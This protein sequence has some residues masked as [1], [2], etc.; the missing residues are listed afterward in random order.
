M[1]AA[2]LIAT[3]NSDT[4]LMQCLRSLQDF[5][6][7]C[8]LDDGSGPE[9]LSIQMAEAYA[10]A[11]PRPPIRARRSP[12]VGQT[13]T[14]LNLIAAPFIEAVC[15]ADSDD[16]RLPGTL[17]RQI[18]LLKAGADVA[19]APVIR[20]SD[21]TLITSPGDPWTMLFQANFASIGIVFRRS[22]LLD[23]LEEWEEHEFEPQEGAPELQLMVDL[24]L[25]GARFAWSRDPVAVCRD[26]HSPT[27]A[28]HRSG[29]VRKWARDRLMA[30]APN[31]AIRDRL[32]ALSPPPD[33]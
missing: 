3:H 13:A 32:L 16:F 24:L 23:L 29:P 15:F 2:A 17:E 5:T 8:L 12:K 7:I 30:H 11:V 10:K 26:R 21:H 9:D 33:A 6:E 25:G 4:H 19:I 18:G 14:K 31:E 22:V 20:D 27:Q 1:R 28:H